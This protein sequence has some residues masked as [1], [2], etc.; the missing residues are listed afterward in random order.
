MPAYEVDIEHRV[1]DQ[2]FSLYHGDEML[3][4][5]VTLLARLHK[6]MPGEFRRITM[7]LD[8]PVYSLCMNYR[9]IEEHKVAALKPRSLRHPGYGVMF[10]EG[11][12]TIVDGHHRLVRRWRGGVRVM[13]F[14]V[15][16][17]DVWRHCLVP[18]SP[19][20]KEMLAE[21]MP[22]RVNDPGVIASSVSLHPKVKK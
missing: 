12:F 22:P 15:S 9:G 4:F 14:W 1:T 6:Q 8:E 3:H 10:E 20:E 2:V 17:E 13:D 21:N 7:D 11:T 16:H 5:N 19:E 18:Y